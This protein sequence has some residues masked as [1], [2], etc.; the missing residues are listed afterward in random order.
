M[1]YSSFVAIALS[2]TSAT[3]AV[4]A[5][6]CTRTHDIKSGEICDSICREESVSLY[7]LMVLNPQ[8]NEECT[9]LVPGSSLCLAQPGEDCQQVYTVVPNDTCEKVAEAHGIDLETFDYNNPHLDP[10]CTNL[11]IDEVVCVAPK[12]IDYHSS[13]PNGTPAPIP[14]PSTA[15][16]ASPTDL[17]WCD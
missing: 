6:S 11:Y 2:F 1:R 7:Q 4:L 13:H 12:R 5:Y 9:N 17:P 14:M 8:I 3:T 15:L 10:A 16:P